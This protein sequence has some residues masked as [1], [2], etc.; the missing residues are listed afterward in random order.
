MQGAALFAAVA[1]VFKHAKNAYIIKRWLES[2]T[3]EL[4][5][6][7]EMRMKHFHRLRMV[8]NSIGIGGLLALTPFMGGAPLMN[9]GGRLAIALLMLL[10]FTAVS[11]I[12]RYI[13]FV[14]VVPRNI[15]GNYI[16]AAKGEAH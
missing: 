9:A 1:F 14:S 16:V 12:N 8:R 15:P 11:F 6:S 13:F 10:L 4:K 3:F 7:A 5:A 2:D